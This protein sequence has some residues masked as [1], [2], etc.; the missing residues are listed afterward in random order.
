MHEDIKEVIR[1]RKLEDRQFNDHKKK[2]NNDLHNIA[3]KTKDWATGNPGMISKLKFIA[4][5][6][7]HCDIHR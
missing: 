4:Y 5:V 6:I 2:E 1:S 3:Q 7:L